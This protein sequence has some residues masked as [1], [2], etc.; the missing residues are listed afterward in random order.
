MER[1]GL[2]EKLRADRQPRDAAGAQLGEVR[3]RDLARVHLDG[4]LRIVDERRQSSL[5]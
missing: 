2:Y 5:G 4:D 3:E 1:P